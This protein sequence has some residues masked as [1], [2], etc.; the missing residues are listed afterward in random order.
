MPIKSAYSFILLFLLISCINKKDIDNGIINHNI[1]VF[2][3][4][5]TEFFK[6]G[7]FLSDYYEVIIDEN[8][9]EHRK[10]WNQFSKYQIYTK[11]GIEIEFEKEMLNDGKPE[12]FKYFISLKNDSTKFPI[13]GWGGLYLIWKDFKIPEQNKFP[14]W[15]INKNTEIVITN[16]S[17]SELKKLYPEFN[18]KYVYG[19]VSKIVINRNWFYHDQDFYEEIEFEGLRL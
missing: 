17:K 12:K 1:P 4:K 6:A 10:K 2:I 13:N 5:Q 19:N 14:N 7:A 11:D 9:E 8:M 16:I 15:Y 18:G 3:E